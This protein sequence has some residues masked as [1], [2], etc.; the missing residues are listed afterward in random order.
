MG[1][2]DK[3][4]GAI[5]DEPQEEVI[6]LQAKLSKLELVEITSTWD[7]CIY[8]LLLFHHS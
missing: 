2:W 7:H 5:K 1:F 3:A 6:D 4:K 8:V